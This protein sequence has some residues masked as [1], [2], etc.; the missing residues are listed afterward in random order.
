MRPAKSVRPGLLACRAVECLIKPFT[1]TALL[2]AVAA[3]NVPLV[4][5]PDTEGPTNTIVQ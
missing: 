2:D 1:E 5:R 4:A 3:L